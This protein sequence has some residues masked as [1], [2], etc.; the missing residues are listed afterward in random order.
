MERRGETNNSDD[1]YENFLR[2]VPAT[3]SVKCRQC[4]AVVY[5]D[6]IQ[7]KVGDRKFSEFSLYASA[8][9]DQILA[10][11]NARDAH[12]TEVVSDPDK[13][14]NHGRPPQLDYYINND[15]VF[16]AF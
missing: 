7:V 12:Y 14:K 3:Y 15:C 13:Y 6:T 11:N 8:T 2:L 5:S 9:K 16:R 1:F 4:N 10:S